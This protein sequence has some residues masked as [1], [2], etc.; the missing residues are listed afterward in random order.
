[1]ASTSEGFA[2]IEELGLVEGAAINETHVR[3]VVV[4]SGSEIQLGASGGNPE[5]FDAMASRMSF[6]NCL[7][8]AR[9]TGVSSGFVPSGE[10][11]NLEM[12]SEWIISLP[13][14]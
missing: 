9:C 10:G 8:I 5:A 2:H 14:A 3:G 1:L 6:S 13:W 4:P 12:N 11:A 7:S